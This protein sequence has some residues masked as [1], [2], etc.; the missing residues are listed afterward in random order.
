MQ[1]LL[2]MLLYFIYAWAARVCWCH[3]HREG[4][5]NQRHERIKAHRPMDGDQMVGLS[6]SGNV[7]DV[8]WPDND[9][10]V[11]RREHREPAQE[12]A[13]ASL[14]SVDTKDHSDED[15]QDYLEAEK[16]VH[17]SQTK[18]SIGFADDLLEE[19]LHAIDHSADSAASVK[20]APNMV[21]N[22]GFDATS[23]WSRECP[24]TGYHGHADVTGTA[25]STRGLWSG[26]SHVGS[27]TSGN[28]WSIKSLTDCYQN[29]RGGVYQDM[30]TTEGVTYE[31]QF[32][33]I[34]AFTDRK[35]SNVTSTL[36]VEVQS[37][38]GNTLLDEA[39]T[40]SGSA[41]EPIEGSWTVIGPYKF[42]PQA[43]GTRIYFYA[44]GSC[45]AMLDD[46]GVHADSEID[47]TPATTQSPQTS[48]TKLVSTTTD[49]I[50]TATESPHTTTQA[51]ATPQATTTTTKGT[52]SSSTTTISTSKETT[53][54]AAAPKT[55]S[56]TQAEEAEATSAS[57]DVSSTAAPFGGEDD[58]VMLAASTAAAAA[59]AKGQKP[60]QQAMAAADAATR[61][62]RA[63]G[64]SAEQVALAAAKSAALAVQTAGG[65][66]QQGCV[67][68]GRAAAYA[69]KSD[70]STPQQ[71]AIAASTAA[72]AALRSVGLPANGMTE[73]LA[74][75]V[76]SAC[77]ATGLQTDAQAE[78]AG[79]TAM[80]ASQSADMTE[81][82]QAE[83]AGKAVV[84][85]EA[86]AKAANDLE[87]DDA[88]TSPPP[89]TTENA[90][91]EAL[92]KEVEKA[93]KAAQDAA[94]AA[95]MAHVE[96][97]KAK[98]NAKTSPPT[99]SSTTTVP[100]TAT[101]EIEVV[102]T[103]A[104]QPALPT[105]PPQ[106]TTPPVQTRSACPDSTRAPRGSWVV[107]NLS[108]TPILHSCLV[109]AVK[110]RVPDECCSAAGT[111]NMVGANFEDLYYSNEYGTC[112]TLT[113]A[114]PLAGS[115]A[116][117]QCNFDNTITY[118]EARCG[119][120]CSCAL[121]DV[122][123][124]G[125]Y[126]ASNALP[127]TAWFFITSGCDCADAKDQPRQE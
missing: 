7:F 104:P 41:S 46:V 63:L 58:E 36:H 28:V 74:L 105:S 101:Y 5:R 35:A 93:K 116:K 53:S 26:A 23:G 102:V 24:E 125:C 82:E 10:P 54:T 112:P 48:T 20:R 115:R 88:G 3:E 70:S 77:K 31:L 67:E 39:F 124:P 45:C 108:T 95:G 12:K 42:K 37:P 30:N 18:K 64:R 65:S 76:K 55:V 68:A 72:F 21:V 9:R 107:Y 49:S 79:S 103:E 47:T 29:T 59:Q 98:A 119:G 14:A 51:P 81:D 32:S 109:G 126:R 50:T 40:L 86:A 52:T 66:L 127:N 69:S 94:V 92:F 110:E 80:A 2:R 62:A 1:P 17:Q 91:I 71:I 38:P 87:N 120:D 6:A 78:C 27:N 114:G 122:Y 100:K 33:A 96:A 22:P 83:V 16:A 34:D 60:H 113:F 13:D 19:L 106:I 43:G 8:S 97:E 111:S 75:S 73:C 85:V 4:A 84:A 123:G 15:V 90:E 44:G 118:G 89:T 56:S 25:C 117:L 57:A 61:T 121:E 11:M 99:T